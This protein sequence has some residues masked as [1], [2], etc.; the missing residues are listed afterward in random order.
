MERREIVFELIKRCDITVVGD[1]TGIV[2]PFRGD[3]IFP[4]LVH[5]EVARSLYNQRLGN[6]SVPF[7][8]LTKI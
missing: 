4:L 6:I 2:L 1:G 3:E 7:M 8:V 5:T